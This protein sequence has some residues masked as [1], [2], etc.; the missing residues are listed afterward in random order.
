MTRPAIL[1][2]VGG[3]GQWV[4]T[5]IKRDLLEINDFKLPANVRLL[6]FDTVPQ[7]TAQTH[8]G[9][10][11]E[12]EVKIGSIK[13]DKDMEFIHLGGNV[14]NLAREVAN[15]NAPYVGGWFD[16]NY[17]IQN[18]PPANFALDSGAGG[19]RP[20]GRIAIFKDLM[21]PSDSKVWLKLQESIRA[22]RSTVAENNQLEVILVGSLVGG[23]GAGMFID[24]ALLARALAQN[25]VG[26]NYHLS[27]FLLLPSAFKGT[28][29]AALERNTKAKTFAAMRELDRFMIVDE[30]FGL[31]EIQY[32]SAGATQKIQV[33]K[34]LFDACYLIEGARDSRSLDSVP[35]E[36]GVYPSIADSISF[37]LDEQSGKRYAEDD[38]VNVAGLQAQHPGEPRYHSLGTFTLRVPIYYM[39]QQRAYQLSKQLVEALTK[40]RINVQ[41]GRVVGLEANLNE[42]IGLGQPGSAEVFSFLSGDRLEYRGETA[43]NTGFNPFLA[44][45]INRYLGSAQKGEMIKMFAQGSLANAKLIKDDVNNWLTGYLVMGN[46]QEAEKMADDVGVVVREV[47]QAVIPTPKALKISNPKGVGPMVQATDEFITSQIGVELANGERAGGRFS[48]ALKRG[49]VFHLNRFSSLLRIW[50]LKTLNG[51]EGTDPLKAKAGKIGYAINLLEGLIQEFNT[52]LEFLDK[53]DAERAKAAIEAMARADLQRREDKVFQEARRRIIFGLFVDPKVH[54]NNNQYLASAQKMLALMRDQILHDQLVQTIRE[55][56]RYCNSAL[57]QLN[58]WT[59][60]LVKGDNPTS[61]ISLRE[62]L[63]NGLGKANESNEID[64]KLQAVRL[65]VQRPEGEIQQELE[66]ELRHFL[67]TI[68]WDV[69][70]EE[71][72]NETRVKVELFFKPKVAEG[73]AEKK[74]PLA[75]EPGGLVAPQQSLVDYNSQTTRELSRT[76][77]SD[78]ERRNSVAEL[79]SDNFTLDELAS[80]LRLN[81]APLYRQTS[82]GNPPEGVQSG[83]LKKSG[84]VRVTVPDIGE[85]AGVVSKKIDE[86]VDK[87]RSNAIFDVQKYGS[88]DA[89]KL[90]AI[91]V[92]NLVANFDFDMWQECREAYV[93]AIS[94]NDNRQNPRT[95]H[96]FPAEGFAVEYELKVSEKLGKGY[97]TFHPKVVTILEDANR[98]RQF[99]FCCM[100]GLVGYRETPYSNDQFFTWQLNLPERP[101]DEPRPIHLTWPA[102]GHLSQAVKE[103]RESIFAAL[104]TFVLSGQD[105]RPGGAMVI[106]YDRVKRALDQKL[107]SFDESVEDVNL[108]TLNNELANLRAKFDY[109]SN[110]TFDAFEPAPAR[111]LIA[112]LVSQE[113]IK[114]K[115]NSGDEF[116]L[117]EYK[118]LGDLFVIM[119]QEEIDRIKKLKNDR[120][121]ARGY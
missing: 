22:V 82:L 92:D 100:Y 71:S 79:V 45:V 18:I 54:T 103:E 78:L 19:L 63:E 67:E 46:S 43:Y 89:A 105:Q 13:L 44:Q 97:R 25:I 7:V 62:N 84:F 101:G 80:E 58:E 99:L 119:L 108:T 59:I 1:I 117:Q 66:Q 107:G 28:T 34:R 32:S 91:T 29:G 23:T 11:K 75:I 35:V 40:P 120:A 20:F 86:I 83:A 52:A 37:I 16:A 31:R 8:K 76:Y 68:H 81:S 17:F 15:G 36:N 2:G 85:R 30:K 70:L 50:L 93:K 47:V 121:R 90:T 51:N 38:R 115:D 87:F 64:G 56:I 26:A 21:R 88:Q 116:V 118:D 98:T 60:Q 69:K 65:S 9:D 96:T 55:Q 113:G 48:D 53:I 6:S 114:R 112:K 104:N 4:L 27:G 3:T 106:S 61:R 110:W 73:E 33:S 14:F 111:G 49:H 74:I 10:E 12:K 94:S 24:I 109:R 57:Q 72:Y 5:Y 41:T 42:E 95:M 102:D 39:K 77:F